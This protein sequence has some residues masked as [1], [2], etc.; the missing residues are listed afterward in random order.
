MCQFLPIYLEIVSCIIVI[1]MLL[2]IFIFAHA[3]VT[4]HQMIGT[5]GDGEEWYSDTQEPYMLSPTDPQKIDVPTSEGCF[6]YD[7]DE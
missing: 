1:P 3:T 5:G 4:G 6:E 2:W 7:E